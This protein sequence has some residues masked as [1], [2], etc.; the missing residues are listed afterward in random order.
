V[1]GWW[2]ALRSHADR[3][4][5]SAELLWQ[6][7]KNNYDSLAETAA[8]GGGPVPNHDVNA[9]RHAPAFM[10]VASFAL[11]TMFK[12]AA[13]QAALNR[14]GVAGIVDRKTR[15][16]KRE[17]SG[18][19]LGQLATLAGVK[20]PRHFQ[21]QVRRFHYYAEW[22]G[23][24]PQDKNLVSPAAPELEHTSSTHDHVVFEKLYDMAVAAYERHVVEGQE[25]ASSHGA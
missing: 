16:I 7:L 18:H 10:L 20:V 2:Q 11:E 19:E 15:K 24:Y 14:H 23:K 25:K 13:F 9:Y 12:A 17:F 21:S 22:A 8:G 1:I 6:P 4:R 3:L 5:G